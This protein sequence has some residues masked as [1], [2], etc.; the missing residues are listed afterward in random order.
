M[1]LLFRSGNLRVAAALIAPW[2]LLLG[3]AGLARAQMGWVAK[4]GIAAQSRGAS[5]YIGLS[6]SDV[7]A[8]RAKAAKLD[9]E[10]GVEVMR[11][12]DGSPAERAGLHTG[13]ILLS[14]NGEPILSG[15][16]LR[17]L[18]AETPPGRKVRLD[19]WRDGK[20]QSTSVITEPL[21]SMESF[22]DRVT[23]PDFP[24]PT[25]SDVTP[26]V[27]LAW[28]VPMLGLECE[29]MGAQL[30]DF[31]GVKHGVLIRSIDSDSGAGKAGLKAGD[32][33]TSIGDQA[34]NSPR[35]LGAFMR[36]PHDVGKPITLVY[37]RGR[38]EFTAKLNGSPDAP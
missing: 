20:P 19:F 22:M 27:L 34:V 17:R 38:K 4:M 12:Q 15:M 1:S 28:K 33:L 35:D 24:Y 14:Y 31:F 26:V 11:V 18:V 30:A 9:R 7:D 29:P 8:E 2:C 5:S 10:R 13:D 6:L 3:A 21:R 16:Q 36:S 37:V 32:I 25:M 23:P